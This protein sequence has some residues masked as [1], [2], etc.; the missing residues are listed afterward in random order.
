MMMLQKSLRKLY[1]PK[2]TTMKKVIY[3]LVALFAAMTF[4]SCND[5]D[6]DYDKTLE[7]EYFYGPQVWG[8]DKPN[9]ASGIGNNN[10]VFYEVNQGETVAVP[11]QFW[12]EF[13]RD[14][15]VV[16]YYWTAPK[17]SGEKYIKEL[18]SYSNS[19]LVSYDGPE[20]VRGVDYEVVDENGNVI[21]P[22]ASG[23]YEMFWP[24]AL[25]GVKNIYIKAL[26]GKKGSFNIMT[27]DPDGT[28]PSGS[29]VSSTIQHATGPYTVRVFSQNYR[30]TVTVK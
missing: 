3:T 4:T 24:N 18:K 12:C 30:V 8:Y 15:N 26:N 29:D 14:Y 10:V 22:G 6:W 13:K 23:A 20:L 9:A 1:L 16:T 19:D 21:A 5:D 7:H 25:K 28:V 17:P 11:M 27:C 2:T